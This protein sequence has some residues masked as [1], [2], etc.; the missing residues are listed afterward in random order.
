MLKVVT[1]LASQRRQGTKKMR[2]VKKVLDTDRHLT[3]DELAKNDLGINQSSIYTIVRDKLNMRCVAACWVPQCLSDDQKKSMHP[4]GTNT[5]M[6]L[7]AI[8]KKW[9]TILEVT[10]LILHD[11]VTCHKHRGWCHC[12]RH[13]TGM[14]YL[15]LPTHWISAPQTDPFPKLKEPLCRV[16]YYDLDDRELEVARQ[17]RNMNSC[18]PAM[19]IRELPQRWESV[20]RK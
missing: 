4:C 12:L 3:C 1:V 20:I 7:P 14:Y 13:I 2:K 8:R 15:T 5:I 17:V 16:H 6:L 10:P 11:N 9:K 19:G 18:G